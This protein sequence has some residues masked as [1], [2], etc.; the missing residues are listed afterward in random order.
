MDEDQ[1]LDYDEGT[2]ET[3]EVVAKTDNSNQTKKVKV[4]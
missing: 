4:N 3:T 2:A 1:L